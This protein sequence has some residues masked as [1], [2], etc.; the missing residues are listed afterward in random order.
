M[1]QKGDEKSPVGLDDMVHAP[2]SF[3]WSNRGA[4]LA[5]E[6]SIPAAPELGVVDAM[7]PTALSTRN[8]PAEKGP[9]VVVA[10]TIEIVPVWP[11]VAEVA[12]VKPALNVPEPSIRQVVPAR[13]AGDRGPPKVNEQLRVVPVETNPPP[14]MLTVCQPGVASVGDITMAPVEDGLDTK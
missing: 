3:G 12:T 11:E 13:S 1:T 6:T 2:T 9:P 10:S 5:I 14:A 8:V 7:A 4:G